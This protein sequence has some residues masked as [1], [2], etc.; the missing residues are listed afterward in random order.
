MLTGI[1]TLLNMET[2]FLASIKATSWGVETM[3]APAS[4]LCACEPD[5]SRLTIDIN[6][7]PEAELHVSRSWRHIDDEHVEVFC[8]SAR[9]PVHIEQQL[10]ERQH[11]A[12]NAAIVRFT[13]C[14]AFMTII[15]RQTTG[16]SFA[17]LGAAMSGE[18]PSGGCQDI[19]SR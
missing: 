1:E 9:C 15:P 10:V 6:Q 17:A 18:Y 8:A 2:P 11:L 19:R 4:Q 7:L 12:S 13:C 16:L 3:T 14:T 5:R